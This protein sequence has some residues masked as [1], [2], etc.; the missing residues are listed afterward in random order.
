M[1]NNV[2]IKV[3]HNLCVGCGSCASKCPKQSI[4]MQEG[5]MGFLYPIVN[6]NTCLDCGLCVKVCPVASKPNR[7]EP[8]DV[9]AAIAKDNCVLTTCNSGGFFTVAA[10]R[11]LRRNGYVCGAVMNDNLEVLHIVTNMIEDIARLQGSKYVQSKTEEVFKP[12]KELLTEEQLVL[13]SGTGCQVAALKSFL[14]K[15]YKNL[16]TI[17]VVC[18]GVPSPGLFRKYIDWLSQING[19]QIESYKFRS[20]HKRPTGEHSEFFYSV[21]GKQMMGC[22]LEDPYYGSF[23]QGR[24]LRE[25]CYNCLFK[26]KSRVADFT[27]GDF[28]GIEKFHKGFPMGHGTSMVMVNTEKGKRWFE[29][30]KEDLNIERSSYEAASSLN[31]SLELTAKTTSELVDYDS[32]TLFEKDLVPI[33]SFKDKIKNR[34]PWQVKQLMKKWL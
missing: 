24:T 10:L 29:E 15:D 30:I 1:N 4:S 11:V 31:H 12:I 2:N 25:S 27:I 7:S 19:S 26:G 33:L 22:S 16:V 21:N 34:L 23:L 8:L 32:A 17:E 3:P 9:Y 13:F 20:K 14:G 6:T 5:S 28:W 18:H